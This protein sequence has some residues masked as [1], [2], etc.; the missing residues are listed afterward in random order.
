MQAML[1]APSFPAMGGPL[2]RELA[3]V[4]FRAVG[5]PALAGGENKGIEDVE[6]GLSSTFHPHPMRK[7]LGL[8]LHALM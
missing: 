2:V 6:L 8:S 3:R 1:P 4:C 7:S 5:G